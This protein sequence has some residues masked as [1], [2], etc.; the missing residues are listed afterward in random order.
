[1]ET[2]RTLN[3]VPDD[4]DAMS[5]EELRQGLKRCQ[6]RGDTLAGISQKTGVHRTTISQLV[7]QG[8]APTFERMSALQEYVRQRDVEPPEYV[9]QLELWQHEEYIKAM[10]WCTHVIQNRKMGVIIGAPGTGKT[11]ILRG[12][13][14]MVQSCIYIEAMSNMRVGD[15]VNTIGR[16][17][18]I[19]LKGNGYQRFQMLLTSLK[20]RTDIAILVD[21]AEYLKKWDVD[22]FEY[23]RKIWDNTGTPVIMVGTAELESI[24]LRGAGRENLAQLYR[25]KN[26]SVLRPYPSRGADS[27][28]IS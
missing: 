25:R 2:A 15:L 19:S 8:I 12:I 21:E 13:S 17:A 27:I 7:N 1:M 3:I 5:I 18:G 9:Q 10:G 20:N 28:H 6:E 14:S 24:L 4:A 22:K 16:L 23:L 11:T 26:A